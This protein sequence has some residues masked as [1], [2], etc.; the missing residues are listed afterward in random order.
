MTAPRESPAQAPSSPRALAT[1]QQCSRLVG[2]IIVLALLIV[3]VA[4]WKRSPT[5]TLGFLTIASALIG[6]PAGWQLVKRN[7]SST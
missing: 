7:G 2:L 5:V 1:W 4:G 3:Y 6:L